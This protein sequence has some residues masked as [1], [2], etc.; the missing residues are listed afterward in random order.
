VL[1]NVQHSNYGFILPQA[2]AE[3]FPAPVIPG[4]QFSPLRTIFSQS[5]VQSHHVRRDHDVSPGGH[6]PQDEGFLAPIIRIPDFHFGHILLQTFP[7]L[8]LLLA[9]GNHVFQ[10]RLES[11]FPCAAVVFTAWRIEFLVGWINDE[12]PENPDMG[13]E[14]GLERCLKSGGAVREQQRFIGI[15]LVEILRNDEGVGD[16]RACADVVN[17][18]ESIVRSTILFR[19]C[20]WNSESF[21]VIFYVRIFHPF[22]AVFNAFEIEAIS[23]MACHTI[24]HY[25]TFISDTPGLPQVW[26]PCSAETRWNV[27][28]D[29]RHISADGRRYVWN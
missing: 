22:G 5:K 9:F 21:A 6:F 25:I 20:W 26:R 16:V 18:W 24:V 10:L 8:D 19:R 15:C 1:H 17:G 14:G 29:D 12:S 23:K 28:E 2:F 13:T 7:L 27:V 11:S 4:L 3:G